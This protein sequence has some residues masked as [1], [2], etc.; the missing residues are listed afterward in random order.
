MYMGGDGPSW[1]LTDGRVRFPGQSVRRD[2]PRPDHQDFRS[3]H[4]L[5]CLICVR[6]GLRSWAL[7]SAVFSAV[8][9]LF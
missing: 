2:V 3:H 9:G 6:R 1:S 4:G 8:V 5:V 7:F